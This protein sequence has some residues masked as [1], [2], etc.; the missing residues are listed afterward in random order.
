MNANYEML[1]DLA[2]GQG[3]VYENARKM[4]GGN[5]TLALLMVKAALANT[6]ESPSAAGVAQCLSMSESGARKK[7]ENIAI[8][9]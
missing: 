9:G 6:T 4:I 1:K 3:E 2:V 5:E 7:I 8:N